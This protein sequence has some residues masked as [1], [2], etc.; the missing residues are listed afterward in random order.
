MIPNAVGEP[1]SP[2]GPAADGAAIGKYAAS[3]GG[4]GWAG[5]EHGARYLFTVE[6]VRAAYSFSNLQDFLDIYYQGADVLRTAPERFRTPG[7]LRLRSHIGWPS[8]RVDT[9]DGGRSRTAR[10]ARLQAVI[11]SCRPAGSTSGSDSPGVGA[12]GFAMD[13]LREAEPATIGSS[14]GLV[15]IDAESEEIAGSPIPR[16]M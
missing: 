1:F 11:A 4:A 5:L 9:S 3:I 16:A 12:A 6:A 10:W 15:N 2:D 7:A 14:A 8:S 13:R